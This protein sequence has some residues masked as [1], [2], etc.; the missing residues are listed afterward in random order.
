LFG[1]RG[2]EARRRWKSRDIFDRI[3]ELINIMDKKILILPISLLAIIIVGILIWQLWP[4]T[5]TPLSKVIVPNNIACTQEAK[6]CHDGSYVTRT[7]PNCEFAECPVVT[8]DET[9][10]WRTYTNK[11]YGFEIKYPNEW[12]YSEETYPEN[13]DLINFTVGFI[14]E[15]QDL[16]FEGSGGMYPISVWVDSDSSQRSRDTKEGNIVVNGS[17]AIKRLSAYDYSISF[18]E[19]DSHG[20]YFSLSESVT[21][22]LSNIKDDSLANDYRPAEGEHSKLFDQMV[23]SFRSNI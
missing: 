7:S 20:H 8:S 5:E 9:A 18:V 21:G 6:L 22:I 13:V 16:G 12:R 3:K 2:F 11:E 23:L 10:N 19:P 4:K 17:T 1:E 14:P 15:G